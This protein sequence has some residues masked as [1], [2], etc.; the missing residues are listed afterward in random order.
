[1]NTGED[2]TNM[3]GPVGS[4]LRE[5]LIWTGSSVYNLLIL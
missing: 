3:P 5:M 1:M 2:L 4:D